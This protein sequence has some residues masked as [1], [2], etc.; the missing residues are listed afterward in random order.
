MESW[1]KKDG[2]L[3][4]T[5]LRIGRSKANQLL[6][7]ILFLATCALFPVDFFLG[8]GIGP[9][10]EVLAAFSIWQAL[11]TY[12]VVTVFKTTHVEHRSILGVVKAAEYPKLIVM[13]GWPES[14]IMIGEDKRGKDFKIRIL[15][16]DG[17]LQAIA[18]FLE[19]TSRR[20]AFISGLKTLGIQ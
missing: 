5:A 11:R 17:D 1:D 10:T 19:A 2:T 13:R 3:M 18:M 9:F 12:V 15:R 8:G 6:L 7:L 20:G 4:P 16:L 14:I